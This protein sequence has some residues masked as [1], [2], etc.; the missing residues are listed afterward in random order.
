MSTK[1]FQLIA[2][3]VMCLCFAGTASAIE[4]VV[5][6]GDP[7]GIPQGFADGALAVSWTQNFTITNGTIRVFNLENGDA[8]P[9]DVQYYLRQSDVNGADFAVALPITVAAGSVRVGVDPDD[10]VFS[11]LNLG[12]GTYF[13][14]GGASNLV[15]WY[16]GDIGSRTTATEASFGSEYA[17]GLNSLGITDLGGLGFS[18]E[19]DIVTGTVPEPSTLLLMGTGLIAAGILRRRRRQ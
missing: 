11:G 2:I 10:P 13:L 6:P 15:G 17:G 16:T 3:L 14:V 9:Q 8:V 5:T 12:P 19:G 4:V 18:V 1:L 7:F